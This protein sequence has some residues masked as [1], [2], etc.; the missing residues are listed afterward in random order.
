MMGRVR[1]VSAVVAALVAAVAVAGAPGA[2]AQPPTARQL[3]LGLR[4]AGL[5]IGAIRVYTAATDG[6]HLLGR[7]GSYTGKAS[8]RDTRIHDGGG[9]FAVSSGGSLEVFASSAAARRR[10]AYVAS[11]FA[12]SSPAVPSEHDVVR[13]RVFLRLSDVLTPA[14]VR[15]YVAALARL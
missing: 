7:P 10:A 8:F 2:T 6:N 4:S 14:Q 15:A 1:S 3:V 11:I 12:S 9:G 13:G 5:P